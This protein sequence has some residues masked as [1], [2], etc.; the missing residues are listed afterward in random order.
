MLFRSNV[1]D[2]AAKTVTRA[3][4]GQKVYIPG[5]IN[6][7]LRTFGGLLPPGWVAEAIGR[8]WLKARRAHDRQPA[9]TALAADTT[10]VEAGYGH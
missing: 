10:N 1:G 8:R 6:Q 9:A 7:T 2:V 4:R 3:L 5:W